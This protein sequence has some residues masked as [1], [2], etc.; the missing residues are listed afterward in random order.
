MITLILFT[1]A[2]ENRAN[3]L[4]KA[5]KKRRTGVMPGQ[6]GARG[7]ISS[8]EPRANGKPKPTV[9]ENLNRVIGLL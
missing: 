4:L 9:T 3:A 5:T 2:K 1:V 7:E 6:A 8:P